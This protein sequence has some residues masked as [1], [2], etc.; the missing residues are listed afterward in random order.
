MNVMVSAAETLELG[1]WR[2]GCN[3]WC[4]W[5]ARGGVKTGMGV[6]RF[7]E[8]RRG[9]GE[10]KSDRRRW[11]VEEM[12]GGVGVGDRKQERGGER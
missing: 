6:S 10:G 1:G 8:N 9:A 3:F 4:E 2:K 12:N 11:Y 5:S 7:V